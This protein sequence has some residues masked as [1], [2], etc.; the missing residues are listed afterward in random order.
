MQTSLVVQYY[1]VA[2]DPVNDCCVATCPLDSG[3]ILPDLN[4]ATRPPICMQ[5]SA[6]LF[7][8]SVTRQ[9]ECQTGHY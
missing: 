4:T 6:G 5:C 8:N 7:F 9:C 2:F 3:I 1:T